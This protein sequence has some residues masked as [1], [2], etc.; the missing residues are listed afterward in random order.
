M[1][2]QLLQLFQTTPTLT[3][4]LYSLR[5]RSNPSLLRK[6]LSMH[7]VELNRLLTGRLAPPYKTQ[8]WLRRLINNITMVPHLFRPFNRFVVRPRLP[9]RLHPLTRRRPASR[10]PPPRPRA[11]RHL[12]QHHFL[13]TPSRRVRLFRRRQEKAS[14]IRLFLSKTPSTMTAQTACSNFLGR[15]P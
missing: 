11:P 9:P 7:N 5:L 14:P 15:V 12:Y 4:I 8:E 2:S 10:R 3:I 13:P 1:D 6:P